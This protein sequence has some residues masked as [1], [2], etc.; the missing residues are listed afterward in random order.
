MKI[1]ALIFV[2]CIIFSAEGCKKD[3]TVTAP[4]T[5]DD[6]TTVYYQIDFFGMHPLRDSEFYVLWIKVA[7]DSSWRMTSVLHIATG[8]PADSAIMFG[9]FT[10]VDS[11]D[12]INDALIT[13]EKSSTPSSIGLPIARC[14]ML[15]IDSSKKHLSST[16]DA[17]QFLRDYSSL[18]GGLVFTST[19]TDS[20]AYTHEF[21]LM[22]LQGIKQTPSLLSLNQP[23]KG[24]K[25]GLWAEDLHFTPHEYFFYGLFSSPDGHDTDSTKDFYPFP[26]GWKPQRMDM[27]SGSIIVTLEPLFYGDSVKFIG[28]SP[29]TLLQFN[30]IRFISKDKNYPMINV[31]LHNIP[32][33]GTITFRRN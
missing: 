17:N 3:N 6:S 30:R 10:M 14:G 19:S 13:L 28:L 29:F 22:N 26:G 18:Q 7:P 27:S 9:K 11:L 31:A 2:L 23:P 21:Y 5:A 16:I 24:W 25:Y 12:N 4:P 1:R 8:S 15:S 32:G 33:G 20:L